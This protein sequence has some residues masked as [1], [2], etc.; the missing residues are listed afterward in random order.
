MTE[1]ELLPQVVWS[2]QLI[3]NKILHLLHSYDIVL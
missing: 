3:Q 2:D 1:D